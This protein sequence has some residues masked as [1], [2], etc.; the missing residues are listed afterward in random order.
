MMWETGLMW[1]WWDRR[2][3]NVR[4]MG[5]YCRYASGSVPAY[6]SAEFA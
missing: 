3:V 4:E 1:L 6:G 2:K 5:F